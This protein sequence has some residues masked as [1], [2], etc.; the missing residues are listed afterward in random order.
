[1]VHCAAKA[2][3]AGFWSFRMRRKFKVSINLFKVSM[4]LNA[5][6]LEHIN[7][8]IKFTTKVIFKFLVQTNYKV[9]QDF[10]LF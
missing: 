2:K 4:N 10:Y 5:D 7:D 3:S 8:N 6:R 1:M 9:F